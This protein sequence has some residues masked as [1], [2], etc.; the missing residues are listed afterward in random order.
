MDQDQRLTAIIDRVRAAE[1]LEAQHVP[2]EL[3]EPKSFL[4]VLRANHYNWS[5]PHFRKLFGMR[6]RVKLPPIEQL[7]ASTTTYRC[8]SFSAW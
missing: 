3:A 1:P 2:A 4:K 5:S 8:S 6:F 7:R